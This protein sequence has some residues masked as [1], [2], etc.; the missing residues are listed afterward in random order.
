MKKRVLIVEDEVDLA[1]L[2]KV[3]LRTKCEAEAISK[4]FANLLTTDVWESVD[5]AIVDINLGE[6]I[7]GIDI[8]EYLQK[9]HPYITRVAYT[10]V[11]R[12][13]EESRAVANV[14]LTK[15]AELEDIE[16][17]VQWTKT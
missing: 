16:E 2:L 9:N 17:A 7:T 10:A 5:V 13:A 14:V 4:D 1:N 11:P 6:D 12:F 8:L 15:P 3:V